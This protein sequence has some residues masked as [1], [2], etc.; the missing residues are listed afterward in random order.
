MHTRHRRRKNYIFSLQVDERLTF[1]HEEIEEVVDSFS[2]GLMREHTVD[3]DTLQFPTFYHMHL[4]ENFVEDEVRM[5][6]K[7]RELDKAHYRT[8]WDCSM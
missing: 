1:D 4:E 6:I 2:E 3:L 7:S 8:A 5:V